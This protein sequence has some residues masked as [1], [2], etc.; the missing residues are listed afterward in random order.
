[1]VSVWSVRSWRCREQ[2]AEPVINSV[3]RYG[4]RVGFNGTNTL[5]GCNL[6]I[7]VPYHALFLVNNQE[8]FSWL[9]RSRCR[10]TLTQPRRNWPA[11][12]FIDHLLVGLLFACEGTFW[13]IDNL[14]EVRIRSVRFCWRSPSKDHISSIVSCELAPIVLLRFGLGGGGVRIGWISRR[15]VQSLCLSFRRSF[16]FWRS[17]KQSWTL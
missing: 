11:C 6:K 7:V 10:P 3:L 1:M 16:L 8:I 14:E 2:I 15:L 13:G 12:L 9:V 4:T 5:G 17:T